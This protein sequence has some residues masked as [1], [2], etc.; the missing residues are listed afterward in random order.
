MDWIKSQHD[1]ATLHVIFRHNDVTEERADLCGNEEELQVAAYRMSVGKQYRPHVH[2]QQ[3]RRTT[4]TEEVLI[5]VCGAVEA[6]YYDVDGEWLGSRLL[7]AGD[8]SVTLR[9]GHAYRALREPTAVYE[10]KNGPYRGQVADKRF[11]AP[12]AKP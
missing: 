8:C 10:I 2:L 12:K 4:H 3:D 7:L 6:W 5:V 1:G 11:L 9:G